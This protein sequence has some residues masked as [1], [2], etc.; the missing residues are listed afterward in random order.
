LA[1]NFAGILY[2]VPKVV[3]ATWEHKKC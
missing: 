1:F 3:K 2:I